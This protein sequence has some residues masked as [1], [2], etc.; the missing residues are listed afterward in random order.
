MKREEAM[1]NLWMK[2]D[3]GART[4]LIHTARLGSGHS[5]PIWKRCQRFDPVRQFR[6]IPLRGLS[7]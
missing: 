6:L 2:S 4:F 7:Y 1:K 5:A 3:G